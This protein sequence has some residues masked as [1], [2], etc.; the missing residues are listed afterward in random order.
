MAAVRPINGARVRSA[1][2]LAG[3]TQHALADIAG[4]TQPH[5]SAIETGGRV[6][7][8]EMIA[9]LA[10]AL[11]V[12]VNWLCGGTDLDAL[13]DIISAEAL[14]SD[15]RTPEGLLE[16]ARDTALLAALDVSPREWG[17]LRTLLTPHPIS[18]W[19]YVAILI[20]VRTNKIHKRGR[21]GVTGLGAASK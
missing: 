13:S 2:K 8:M 10:K 17:M 7:S 3:L 9:S 11:G 21:S 15:P 5:V 1:R 16:F 18:K 20:A 19:G 4:T 14:S 12:T 6:G